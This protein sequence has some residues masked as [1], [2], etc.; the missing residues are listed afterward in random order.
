MWLF[1]AGKWDMA[2]RV[3]QYR[4][5]LAEVFKYMEQQ[6]QFYTDMSLV[7]MEYPNGTRHGPYGSG[8]IIDCRGPD[9]DILGP[10]G[11]NIN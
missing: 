5:R 10:G 4:G 9:L 8:A 6:A 1:E 11:Q 3:H 7:Q 2:K